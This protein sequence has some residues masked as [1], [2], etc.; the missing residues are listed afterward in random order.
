MYFYIQVNKL[1]CKVS[2]LP[3]FR[4]RGSWSN[5]LVGKSI[6]MHTLIHNQLQ[7]P[8]CRDKV[9]TVWCKL[10]TLWSFLL[11]KSSCISSWSKN[12]KMR[13]HHTYS[14]DA[15]GDTHFCFFYVCSEC[16]PESYKPLNPSLICSILFWQ[17][18]KSFTVG[19]YWC[20][21]SLLRWETNCE[22][23]ALECEWTKKE[24]KNNS[25]TKAENIV[26]S[27]AIINMVLK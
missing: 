20:I 10:I 19:K 9:W 17:C 5:Y 4:S 12:C 25:K 16:Y 15:H 8:M 6:K 11:C 7:A 26:T 14:L 2:E 18:V 24:N 27:K 3:S 1:H 21:F 22:P 23:F 13:V